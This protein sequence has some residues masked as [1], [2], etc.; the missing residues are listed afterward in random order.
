MTTLP[1]VKRKV[2]IVLKDVARWAAGGTC[3]EK[4]GSSLEERS[5]PLDAVQRSATEPR[6]CA[7]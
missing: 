1:P 7:S 6:A 3:K 4:R 2:A 5:E